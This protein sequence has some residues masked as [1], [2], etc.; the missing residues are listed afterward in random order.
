MTDSTDSLPRHKDDFD[1]VYDLDDPSPYFTAL[2]PA[3]YRMPAVL[4]GA[5]KTVHRPV[6]AA[7]GTGD[8]LRVLDFACG[9]GVVGALLRHDVSMAEIYARYGGRRWRPADARSHWEA[10]ASFFAARREAGTAFEIG[11]IDIAG[12]ALEYAQTL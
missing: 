4:A 3:D 11:G 1:R 10:D 6:C 9:Y 2:I 7:R 8:T 12:T 5:L